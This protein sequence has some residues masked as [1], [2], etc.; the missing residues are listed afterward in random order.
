M[1]QQELDDLKLQPRVAAWRIAL[2]QK[3]DSS[4]VQRFIVAVILVNSVILGLETSPAMMAR[5]GGLLV[6]LDKLCLFIF[7]AELVA[8]LAAYRGRFWRSGWNVF[9]FLVV[10]V[11]LAPGA[12]P[13]AVLRSLRVLRVLRLLTVIPSLRKVVAAFLHSIPGLAGVV[14]VMSIFFYT[15]AVLATRLFGEA[16]P[17][18]FGSFPRSLYTLFQVM[19]L[20][21]WSMGIVRPVMEQFPW[22]WAFFVPFIIIA[23]F[24]ILNLFIG[25][26]VSTMQELSMQP[27]A[28][29]DGSAKSPGE[30]AVV[31]ARIEQDLQTLRGMMETPPVVR[32][33]S[34]GE[35]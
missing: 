17:D 18:W 26:I 22:A 5:A 8:K 12:G 7:L 1:G 6:A 33:P 32:K 3:V 10:A 24:T 2:A 16:F 13:W 31:L 20:E 15:A 25:I 4:G 30:A 28:S 35:E 14:A 29:A 27:E 19:T 21:S 9:D 23:T 34:G 11:A